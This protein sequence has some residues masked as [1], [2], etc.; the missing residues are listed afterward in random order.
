[1]IK[2]KRF[3]LEKDYDCEG[4]YEYCYQDNKT[5]ER[6]N[7]A[8]EN[9]ETDF[10]ELVNSVIYD[11]TKENMELKERNNRQYKQL[12][13]LYDLIEHSDWETLIELINELKENEKQLQR[14]WKCYSD[15]V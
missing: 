8:D 7:F 10:L 6:F 4:S 3:S 13:E 1:M 14:E 12:K 5:G 11:L 2:D 15:G 9:C